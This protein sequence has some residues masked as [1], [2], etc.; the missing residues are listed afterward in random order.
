MIHATDTESDE[1]Y[2]LPGAISPRRR[3]TAVRV[4]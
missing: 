4:P 3:K 2:H 1:K